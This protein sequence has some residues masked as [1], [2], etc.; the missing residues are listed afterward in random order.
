M[1]RHGLTLLYENIEV[2]LA[3]VV[4]TIVFF[5]IWEKKFR[6][7]S[8]DPNDDQTDHFKEKVFDVS[9]MDIIGNKVGV[10]FLVFLVLI[11]LALCRI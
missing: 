7:E 3:M 10:L 6:K 9:R 8:I 5:V 2:I 4:I 11:Y 1:K